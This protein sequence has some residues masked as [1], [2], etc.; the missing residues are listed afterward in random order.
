MRRFL[1]DP[2]DTGTP[3]GTVQL[4]ARIFQGELISATSTQFL[5]AALVATSTGKNRLKGMLPP[6]TVVA[7]KTGTTATIDGLNGGTND[8]GVISLPGNAGRLA[9]A[10]YISGSS[11]EEA[12]RD[13][14]IARIARAAYDTWAI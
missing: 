2:R 11:R 12:T 8:V 13:L 14:I 9:I 6:N 7:H 10:V 1:R 3:D 5:Q 4:L